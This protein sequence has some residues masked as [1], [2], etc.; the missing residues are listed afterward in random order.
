MPTEKQKP[1]NSI[2]SMSLSLTEQMLSEMPES[3]LTLRGMIRDRKITKDL[4]E[5]EEFHGLWGQV[6]DHL[7][8]SDPQIFW[9]TLSTLGR[10][11]AVS[12]PAER[13]VVP[14]LKRRFKAPLGDFVRLPDGEDRYYLSKA[15]EY[16]PNSEIVDIAFR[17]LAEEE[18]AETARRVWGAIAGSKATSLTGFLER[19]NNEIE[20]VSK[21]TRPTPDTLCRRIRRIVSAIGDYLATADLDPGDEVGKQLRVL[22]LGHLPRSGPED[23][24]LRE[25]ASQDFLSAVQKITRLNISARTDPE[26]YRLIDAMRGWWS[27]ASPSHDFDSAT[28]RI[29][30]L[31]VESLVMF[32]KQG[33]KNKP[34][35]EALVSAAGERFVGSVADDFASRAPSLE[36]SVAF[37]FVT[38]EEPKEERSARGVEALSEAKLDE[39]VGRLLIALDAQGLK[40]SVVEQALSAVKDIMPD[41][42]ELL[43][44]TVKRIAPVKQWARAVARARR[45]ELNPDRSEVVRYDPSVHTGDDGLKLGSEVRVLTPG[46]VK[47]GR[48]GLRIVLVKAEVE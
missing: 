27:P 35:R 19:L 33:V 29:A 42:G 14:L 20:T 3:L 9:V 41:E 48:G 16:D 7:E 13:L 5:S 6:R 15:L 37:W 34:L 40:S 17:E 4:F 31:G 28:R 32:A 11:A 25:E 43:E 44:R 30:R 39:Y 18:A 12:K 1:R 26:S 36:Q 24:A 45:L 21:E 46:V 23:R 22:F 2:E 47:E 38:G 8:T 10:M